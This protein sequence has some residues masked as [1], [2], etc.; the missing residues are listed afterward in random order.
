MW[1]FWSPSPE[2][3]HQV[4]I[5]FSDRGLPNSYPNINGYGSHTYSFINADNRRFWVKFHFKTMQGIVNLTKAKP[6]RLVGDDRETH[7]RRQ[8]EHFTKA[9]S[10]YGQGVAERL[11]LVPKLQ[12]VE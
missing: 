5:L 11:G 7:Q 2:S 12:A 3:L 8:V 4:T 1:D 6:A 9:D 10:A